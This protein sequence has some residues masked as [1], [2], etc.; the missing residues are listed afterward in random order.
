MVLFNANSNKIMEKKFLIKPKISFIKYLLISFLVLSYF[1]A[2][3]DAAPKYS[4]EVLITIL[5]N[6]NNRIT[7]DSICAIVNNNK[8]AILTYNT[9]DYWTKP[10]IREFKG[11]YSIHYNSHRIYSFKLII[12]K[13]GQKYESETYPGKNIYIF[14]L[15]N[16]ILVDKSPFFHEYWSNYFLSLIITLIAETL[17]GLKYYKKSKAK[18]KISAKNYSSTFILLNFITHFLVWTTYSYF[19]IFMFSLELLVVFAELFYW[20]YY[21]KYSFTKSFFIS[22]LTNMVSWITGGVIMLFVNEFKW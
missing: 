21:L 11:E 5:D 4:D 20:K 18:L 10:T 13:N 6:N 16:N 3:A 22:L 8:Y 2:N 14:K 17:L 12:F 1:F 9:F 19:V 7:V 15:K